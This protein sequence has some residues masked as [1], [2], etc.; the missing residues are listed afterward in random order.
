MSYNIDIL[1]LKLDGYSIN[2]ISNILN[3]DIDV[4]KYIYDNDNFEIVH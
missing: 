2:E 1:L 3:L 4:I